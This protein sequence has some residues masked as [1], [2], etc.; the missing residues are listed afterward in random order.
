[1]WIEKLDV[2]N[3]KLFEK[4]NFSFHPQFNLIVGENGSGKTS[5]MDLLATCIS[6]WIQDID[7]M[8][9]IRDYFFPKNVIRTEVFDYEGE[10]R[11]SYSGYIL[12]ETEWQDVP[13]ISG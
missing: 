8:E 1:M 6:A 10:L 11:N 5:S 12:I 2:E 13:V 4:R 7:S 3:F 9:Y